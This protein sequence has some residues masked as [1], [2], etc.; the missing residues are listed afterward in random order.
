[1]AKHQHSNLYR[2]ITRLRWQAALLALVLVLIHQ[3]IEHAYLFFLPRWHHFWTQVLFYGLVGPALAWL[4]LTSLR[5]QVLE[6]E[7]AE[8][9]LRQANEALAR[10]NE[11]LEFLIRVN[12]H[13]AE[14]EDEEDLLQRVVSL[15]LQAV[16]ALGCTLIRFD[17]RQQ[18][19][20]ALHHGQLPPEVF[21]AWAAHLSAPEARQACGTCHARN[22]TQNV[23]CPILQA[24]PQGLQVAKIHCL[25][26]RRGDREVGVL[27][28]YLMETDR[29]TPQE[30]ALLQALA[31]E[32]ALALESHRLRAREL[33]TLYR[34]QQVSR[35]D[36]L[37]A[38]LADGLERVVQALEVEGG[39]LFLRQEGQ[40][41]WVLTVEVGEPLRDSLD[42]VRGLARG[43]EGADRPL[44]LG[45]LELEAGPQ[46]RIG[47][48]LVAP[49]RKESGAEGGLVLWSRQARAFSRRHAQLLA[50][51]AWQTAL[52]LENHRLYLRAE[53]EASL[54]ERARL[55]R[56]IHDGLAQNLGYLKLRAGQVLG[57][58]REGRQ[59]AALEGLAEIRRLLDEAYVDAREAIDGLRVQPGEG[60]LEDWLDQ[61]L[62]E[63]QDL[64]GIPVRRSPAPPVDLPP[65]VQAQLLRIVQEA[66]GNI[67]KHSGASQAEVLWD[68]TEHWLT[69]RIRDNGRGFAPEDVP[70]ISRHGLRIMRERA[71]LLNADFQV[72]SRPGAGTE[73]V[74][75]LPLPEAESADPHD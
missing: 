19:L 58:L 32:M 46:R 23:P 45:D 44:L 7:R 2:R 38:E 27:N 20:P 50:A 71:E 66:L 69:L 35:A 1:M 4:A 52:L 63:F 72:I 9:A 33:E 41:D 16:P 12:R 64:S 42:L 30:A 26:L 3:Y 10:A 25:P 61:V 67:R 36:N 48:L 51:I 62:E 73:V 68:R 40:A 55:A 24:A 11:R 57:W 39:A 14:A 43:A 5:Q 18:P 47:S 59:Q 49:M 17:E 21:D 8:G 37:K 54:A 22:A 74:V 34:L 15:P 31:D 70:P 53:Y 65:E 6:T 13:L 75:R 29:P 60:T 28:L 56:E